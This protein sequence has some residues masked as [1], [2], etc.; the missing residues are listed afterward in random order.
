MT[1]TGK[2]LLIAVLCVILIALTCFFSGRDI[3]YKNGYKAGYDAGYTEC[4]ETMTMPFEVKH[5]TVQASVAVQTSTQTTVRPKTAQD[6]ASVVIKTE[7]PKIVATVNGKKYD[8]KP[9]SQVLDN[10]VTTTGV[11][12]V[13]VPERRWV[14]G[15][16]YG[17]DKKVSYMLKAPIGKS[18]VGVWVAGSGKHNVMGGVSVSF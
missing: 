9:Q 16:G 10:T 5:D 14:A 8:F 18:A 12:N 2:G 13:R 1:L 15:I 6:T 7:E 17:K 11:I 3:G 4:A